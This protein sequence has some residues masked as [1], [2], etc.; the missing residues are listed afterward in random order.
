MFSLAPINFD[1]S[2]A[3][4][5]RIPYLEQIQIET[6]IINSVND[7]V[8]EWDQYKTPLGSDSRNAR[9]LFASVDHFLSNG[10][11]EGNRSF[12][13]NWPLVRKHY[14]IAAMIRKR[15]VTKR[16]FT[17]LS[18]I[19]DVQFCFSV[20]NKV[21]ESA[22]IAVVRL[23][24]Q[25]NTV[26]STSK[27]PL[28]RTNV[29]RKKRYRHQHTESER[30]SDGV[31]SAISDIH[32]A[33]DLIENAPD[34]PTLPFLSTKKDFDYV[35]AEIVEK[36]E[37]ESTLGDST[38][39]NLLDNQNCDSEVKQVFLRDGLSPDKNKNISS[40]NG[41]TVEND[42]KVIENPFAVA[43]K[44]SISQA[45]LLS[46]RE[47]CDNPQK[48]QSPLPL[49]ADSAPLGEVCLD[50]GEVIGL[51][52]NVFKTEM[53]KYL[54][55]FQ[56][57]EKFGTG[58]P[59]KRFL[60]L[61]N[62]S[63][64]VLALED[65]EGSTRKSYVTLAYI[66]L[67]RIE[68][69]YVSPDYQALFIHIEKGF[70]AVQIE[71]G[72]KVVEICTGSE[73]LGETIVHAVSL[74]YSNAVDNKELDP[75]KFI[76]VALNVSKICGDDSEK[77]FQLEFQNGDKLQFLC[78]SREEMEKWIFL[79]NRAISSTGKENEAVGCVVAISEHNVLIAQEGEN[80]VVDGFMRVLY[81]VKVEDIL[82]VTGVVGRDRFACVLTTENKLDWL[83]LRTPDE[84]DRVLYLLEK[85][86]VKRI[87]REEDGSSRLVALI[88]SLPM[89]GNLFYFDYFE[90]LNN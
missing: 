87:S 64:Y 57:Y 48:S 15:D 88:N 76:E 5:S 7:V 72:A 41:T 58:H 50:V 39:T 86:K 17:K 60:V 25:T 46:T 67:S 68:F 16:I 22:P 66:P 34:P 26:A 82:N 32:V 44:S 11:V 85:L 73:R 4:T 30:F 9:N 49:F 33:P 10:C 90:S 2:L 79:L 21:Q 43:L 89:Y 18:E 1:S 23:P 8:A 78:Q 24:Q 56:V 19:T 61:S 69:I 80:C 37:K 84:V 35:F 83:F 14:T 42:K 28:Q 47:D 31:F 13:L 20:R 12:L 3:G 59:K 53:E 27:T 6:L 51:S 75:L 29:K 81:I 71:G 70:A 36:S 38:S 62:L 63:V 54:R 65:A 77:K 52:I 74:A 55:F 40:R 45:K